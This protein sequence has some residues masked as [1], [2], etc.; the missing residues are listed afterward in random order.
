MRTERNGYPYVRVGGGKKDHIM[1]EETRI[2]DHTLCGLPLTDSQ[3]STTRYRR[4]VGVPTDVC[5]AC[6]AAYKRR[7]GTH[8][9]HE[10]LP[11][12]GWLRIIEEGGYFWVLVFDRRIVRS[13]DE[14]LANQFA[15]KLE[16]EGFVE[17]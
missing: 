17:L 9:L 2:P 10:I 8:P 11:E 3:V 14:F 1:V 5:A 13:K 4:T 6:A 12:F 16:D 7:F 15:R